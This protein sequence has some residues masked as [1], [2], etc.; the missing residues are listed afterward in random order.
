MSVV[1]TEKAAA[2][3]RKA[4]G[5]HASEGELALRIAVAGGGCSGFEYRLGLERQVDAENDV[6]E[7][8]HGV[9]VV[10]DKK[11]ELFLT[12]TEVDYH[13]GLDKRGFSFNNPNAKSSCGCGTSF[14]V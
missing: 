11:S 2:E 1:L 6:V 9:K 7:E 3:I 10:V 12:G 8:Q 14:G 4:I 13:D 5:D